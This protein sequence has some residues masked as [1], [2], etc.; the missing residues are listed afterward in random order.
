MANHVSGK[1]GCREHKRQIVC[2]LSPEINS[3]I[4]KVSLENNRTRQSM[5]AFAINSQ[6]K[7]LE[8]EPLLDEW[9]K[10]VVRIPSRRRSPRIKASGRTGKYALAGWFRQETVDKIALEI[11]KRDLNFQILAE[12]GMLYILETYGASTT[13]GQAM[14]V[15]HHNAEEDLPSVNDTG[16]PMTPSV[17]HTNKTS[18]ASNITTADTLEFPSNLDAGDISGIPDF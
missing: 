11:S 15:E 12:M 6:L 1:T 3:E 2:Y 18:D 14:P 8:I 9:S 5:L 17:A 16:E 10:R 13:G 4:Y 7:S